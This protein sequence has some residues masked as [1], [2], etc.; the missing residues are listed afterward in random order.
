MR[1]RKVMEEKGIPVQGLGGGDALMMSVHWKI[2]H[3]TRTHLTGATS[4]KT[5]RG[6]AWVEKRSNKDDVEERKSPD[7]AGATSVKM[8]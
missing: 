6:S 2:K 8:T 4:V 1:K 7:E 5:T 3:A